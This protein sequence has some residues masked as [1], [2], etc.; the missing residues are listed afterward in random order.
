LHA[1]LIAALGLFLSACGPATAAGVFLCAQ[2]AASI[3]V[4][5][6]TSLARRSII[7]AGHGA[8]PHN[9]TA[10][11][12]AGG[13][14]ATN[15][16]MHGGADELLFIDPTQAE[17]SW[18]LPLEVGAGLAHVVVS[19]DGARA[20]ATG[21]A[22]SRVFAVNLET[23]ERLADLEFPAGRKP[24]GLRFSPDGAL[25]Y[26]ANGASPVAQGGVAELDAATGK[27]LREFPLAGPAIQVA[28]SERKVFASVQ[29]P[30]SVACI[31]RATGQVET[32]A[33]PAG[34][35]APAQPLLEPDH[36]EL[37]AAEQ[38]TAAEP[39][40]RLFELSTDSGELLRRF[41]VGR[42][43]HGIVVSADGR[44]AFVTALFDHTLAVVDLRSGETRQLADVARG[45]NGL[46]VWPP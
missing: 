10:S 32:W 18:R 43:A 40:A 3:D 38:G 36:Q 33:L 25:L 17:V 6:G 45:P 12:S 7:A 4:R 22:T 1:R 42:G 8:M 39:G 37:M 29:S 41:E 34:A 28:V 2:D 27:L 23:R 31:D 35:G 15:A 9:I 11:T 14:V 13:L 30:P 44:L 26:T 20:F 21:Y 46:A 16:Q 5:D 19:P 24:H